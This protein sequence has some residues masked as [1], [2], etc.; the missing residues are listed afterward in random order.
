MEAEYDQEF[1]G[2]ACA[3]VTAGSKET[4]KRLMHIVKVVDRAGG[5]R[6]SHNSV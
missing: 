3:C 2:Y 6:L 4:E 1:V 5:F